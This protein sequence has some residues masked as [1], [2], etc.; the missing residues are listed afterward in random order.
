MDFTRPGME[1]WLASQLRP[2]SKQGIDCW[3]LDL[4]EPEGEPASAVYYAGKSADI[5]NTVPL[6]NFR[7][8]FDYQRSIDPIGRPVILGRAATAGTQRYSGIV[9]TGDI[10]SDWPTF[11]AHIPEVQNSGLSG[12]PYWANDSGGFLSGFLHR[13]RCGTHAELYERWFEFTCFAPI[14]RAHKSGPAEPYEYGPVVE[15]TAKKYLQLRYRLL[16]YI[17]TVAHATATTG[18]PMVRPLILEYQN[19]PG[20]AM[21]KTEFM[22]G[23]D[24]LVAPVIWPGATNR[25]V[26]FPPSNWISYDEGFETP[27][28]TNLIVAAPHDRIP[29]F[30][31][32]G[33]ILP[34]APDMMYTGEK[35]WDPITL[36]VWPKGDSTGSLYEDDDHTTAYIQGDSTTTFFHCVE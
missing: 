36:N 23:D 13:D 20:S 16:P 8:Y 3:W 14:T 34:T 35:P 24:L 32:A 11:R 21:A 2:L 17:Y 29:L 1:P 22:F 6:L 31:R 33:T 19:D 7:T 28:V 18:L 15:A 30:V 25:E 4:I 26:Y 9:W 10:N 12:L 5:H 27:G